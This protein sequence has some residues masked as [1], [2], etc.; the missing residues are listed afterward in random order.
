MKEPEEE[1]TRVRDY[2]LGHLD[3]GGRR[4]IEERLMTDPDYLEEVLIVESELMEEYLDG[5]LPEG[6]REGF[7][8][9]VLATQSQGEKLTAAKALSMTARVDAAANSPPKAKRSTRPFSLKHWFSGLPRTKS[10]AAKLSLAA[11][12]LVVIFGTVAAIRSLLNRGMSLEQEVQK[13][14]AQQYMDNNAIFHGFIIGPLRSGIFRDEEINQLVI[15]ETERMVQARLRV[16]P[17]D[18]RSFQATLQTVEGKKVLSLSD[19]KEQRIDSERLVIV[20]LP[21]RI[22]TPGDYHLSLS[23]LTQNGQPEYL[24]RYTFRILRN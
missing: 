18:Y 13:L 7:V 1:Q 5:V 2:L 11:V 6:D 9:H 3:E 15:P 24:G 20:Y 17:G 19:L 16:G 22:L 4:E 12:I 23:G 14:N 21:T 10:R 8:R